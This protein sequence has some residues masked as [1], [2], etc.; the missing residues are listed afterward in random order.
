MSIQFIVFLLYF[1]VVFAIGFYSLRTTQDEQDYWIAGGNLGWLIGGST[2]AAT[3]TSAGTFIGTIGVIY[4]AGWSF[5]WLILAVVFAYWFMAAVLAPRF[6]KVKQ[7]TLPA[8]ME[9]RYY[10]KSARGVAAIIILIATVVYIQAQI[11]AGGLVANVVFGIA[12]TQ[13]MIIFT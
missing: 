8:F 11:V 3:H 6:T 13:G 10:S 1:L 12:P 5:G 9:T 4:T 2:L 7:L